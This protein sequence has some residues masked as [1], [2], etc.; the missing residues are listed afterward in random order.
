MD[1]TA[2]DVQIAFHRLA[3][4][5]S[6]CRS[7][8]PPATLAHRLKVCVPSA[9]TL[10]PTLPCSLLQQQGCRLSNTHLSLLLQLLGEGA[11]YVSGILGKVGPG[12]Q[13]QPCVRLPLLH[14]STLVAS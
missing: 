10:V 2:G 14:S 1:V 3:L 8:L 9:G 12:G 13:E 6:V 11:T 5:I 7:V 4:R